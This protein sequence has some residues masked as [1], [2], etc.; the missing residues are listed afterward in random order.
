[1]YKIKLTPFANIFYTEWLLEP[2]GFRYNLVIDQILYGVLDVFR[3]KNALKRYIADH[4]ILNSHIK[5]INGIPYW[6]KNKNIFELEYSD[7]QPKHDELLHYVT[8]AFDLNNGPLY[9]FKLIKISA[10][11]YR[12]IVVIHHIAVDGSSAENGLFIA[13]A[14]YYND[15]DYSIKHSID[16]QIRLL[17]NLAENLAIK[18]DCSKVKQENFWSK[19][20]LDIQP[21]NLNFLQAY[22]N[23]EEIISKQI[24]NP[25]SEIR[26]NYGEEEA[27]KLHQIKRHYV[28]TPY[29]Y[30][31]CV[32]AILL[33][34]YTNQEQF[35]ISY[36]I[37]IKEG[38]DF[39]YGTQ[40]NTNIIPFKFNASL[41]I[42]DCLMQ[43]KSFFKS[44]KSQEINYGYYPINSIIYQN[45]KDILNVSFIQTNL[46]DDRI[47][48]KGIN[49]VMVLFELHIDSVSTKT[50]LFEQDLKNN[51]SYRIRYDSNNFNKV[52]VN[53]FASTYKRLFLEI[54]DDLLNGNTKK[55]I[56]TYKLLSTK[57]YH[58]IVYK[59][60]QTAKEYP[61]DK[62][63]HQL[64]EEQVLKTPDNIAVVYEE[65]K[66]TYQELNQKANQLAHYLLDKYAIEP[67][68]LVALCLNR[69]EYMLIAM[70]AVLK[71]GGAYV[72]IEPSYPDARIKYICDDSNAKVIIINAEHE[73]K[74]SQKLNQ[75][76][77]AIEIL[78]VENESI[79]KIQTISN[80]INDATSQNL[81]Y[82]I[83]TSGTTGKPK[84]IMQQ[85]GNIMR[86]F[87]ATNAWYNF[88]NKD[89]WILFHSYAFDFSVWEIWGALIYGGKLIMP[90]TT[91]SKD[92][93][94]FYE[95]CWQ[96]KV[97]V[98]NQ[99][100]Q[101][102]Y[103]FI[104]VANGKS[105]DAKLLNLKYVIFGGEALNF[106]N[107]KPWIDLY[108]YRT[109]KL[110][111]MYGITETTVHATYKEITDKDI[112]QCS[113]IGK[114]IPDQKIY[115]LDRDL[116]PLP[117]GVVGELYIGGMGL[118]RGYLNQPELTA[119]KFIPNPFEVDSRIYKSG[120]LAR[121]LPDGNL[122]YI[123]RNDF[124]V[125]IRGFRIE[126]GEI[127]NKLLAY[128]DIKQVAVLV[129]GGIKDSSLQQTDKYI[130]AYYVADQKLNEVEIYDYLT[131][132]LPDY[133]LPSILIYLKKLPLTSNGK[134][135]RTALPKPKFVT[136]ERYVKPKSEVEKTI[137]L[138]FVS[139]LKIKKVGINDDF[140][141]LGG[142]SLK[143]IT[144][145]S[146]L[147][148]NFDVNVSHIFNLRTP[149]KLAANLHIRK[150]V[151]VKNL[152]QIEMLYADKLNRKSSLDKK[153]ADRMTN[154]L[155]NIENLQL[156]NPARKSMGNVLLTGATGF[157]GCNLL[158]QLLK[159]TDY[160]IYLPVRASSHAEAVDRINKKFKFYFDEE[161]GSSS[162]VFAENA[163]RIIIF[164]ADL[165]KTNLGLSAQEYQ[166]LAY[167]IDSTIHAAALVKHYG[168][169]D[170]FYATNVQATINLLEF[171]R[172]TALKDFHYISTSS[173]LNCGLIPDHDEYIYTEDDFP[174]DI[175]QHNNVYVQTKFY[176]EQQVVEYRKYGINS[177][178]YRVGNLAFIAENGRVQENV[179]DNAFLNW[180]KC[181]I[182]LQC[183]P[184]ELSIVE[185][186]PVDMTAQAIV[187]IFDKK[188]LNN[189]VYH[190]INPNFVDLSQITLPEGNMKIKVLPLP[191]F[192]NKVVY[193]LNGHYNELV[194]KF[195]LHQG[196]L[197]GPSVE[198][199]TVITI[200]QNRTTHILNQ[201][202]FEW[203]PI[204]NVVFN[205]LVQL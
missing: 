189:N 75:Q 47:V 54:L 102:F 196:W 185:I 63:I 22:K 66:L 187:K 28:I 174:L 176:G 7:C 3:L 46:G 37:V 127:E 186:S 93:H 85:H 88:S 122:E 134:L 177:N 167:N 4:I 193:N 71:A 26:F 74:L 175:Q 79:E 184:K 183:I 112:G 139:V 166:E 104:S 24:N 44:L 13:I 50:L 155:K 17:T 157:L 198:N 27:N 52:L 8:N 182:K 83:Y 164:A 148:T 125:K 169:Y 117:I 34:R 161:L 70:L 21:I 154:Y 10:E 59:F 67:D 199:T 53:N 162:N 126:L 202:G 140:F 100:P 48:F 141:K 89:T 90:T 6:I 171:T 101:A 111:N 81:I 204:A 144:L 109:P 203:M 194:L 42:I 124:Q 69:N 73:N 178:I 77:T 156:T 31:L 116:H 61:K 20:L 130:V 62:T 91:Q 45:N 191:N 181:L 119:E 97:T 41:T 114:A 29:I 2:S 150:D 82:V 18:L 78:V 65:K 165:E 120:D 98:L 133:M 179:D 197:D 152:K 64:F 192:I 15:E 200:L 36:P 163:P 149:C 39:I 138:A 153:A 135:D 108:G 121:W 87:T 143:A 9:R 56:S 23:N 168:D 145:T 55:S 118:A 106:I 80:P 68:N 131:D 137:C 11:A 5:E 1:M 172:L 160:I 190:L 188:L 43:V 95:L 195:L 136:N 180:L 142:N 84:G 110:I 129:N 72:P 58:K 92:T 40:L 33:Y 96:Q 170:Q 113:N 151:I 60:N 158:N 12:F 159:H 115:I 132:Q 86:L 57:Q 94:L 123:G 19:K 51:L 105:N 14:K 147:Q 201:L 107:L 25:I 146:I 16:E 76:D 32:F 38:L 30:S 173:V 99:T 35:G 205:K 103:N 49:N 128:P